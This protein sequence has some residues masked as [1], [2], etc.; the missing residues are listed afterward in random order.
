MKWLFYDPPK[1]EG[2]SRDKIQTG[3]SELVQQRTTSLTLY[4]AL[5]YEP[6]GS[7]LCS[8]AS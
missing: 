5:S 4:Y 1:V 7:Y 8:N 2:F 3:W 6:P